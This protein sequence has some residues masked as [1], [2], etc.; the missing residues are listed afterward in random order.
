M[1]APHQ[2]LNPGGASRYDP[3]SKAT[4]SSSSLLHTF[5][6]KLAP[7]ETVTVL[8]NAYPEAIYARDWNGNTPMQLVKDGKERLR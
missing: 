7:L 6:A 4:P 8:L 5:L 3:I 2:I 1:V